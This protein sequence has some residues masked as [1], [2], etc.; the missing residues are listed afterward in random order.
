MEIKPKNLTEALE[1]KESY[2][3]Y[4]RNEF[5][6]LHSK[7]NKTNDDKLKIS[8]LFLFINK[9]CFRGMYR[10]GPNGYN[11][12]GIIKT[13]EIVTLE[14]LLCVS[15]LI[16]KVKFKHLDFRKSLDKVLDKDFVYLDPPYAPKDNK[17]FVKYN[18][19]GFNL[20]CHNQLFDKIKKLNSKFLLSNAKV[21]LVTNAFNEESYNIE[22]ILA[23][24]SI[25]SKNPG[26]K[27][28][29]VLISN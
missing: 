11:V 22:T 24:R 6:K 16:K 8:V 12:F 13:P 27:T 1:S 25:N 5:N 20:D 29:E 18:K 9:T 17:S 21:E 28:E 2:Y 26:S 19:S 3:Y 23:K 4:L 10:E 15:K 7:D 14:Q